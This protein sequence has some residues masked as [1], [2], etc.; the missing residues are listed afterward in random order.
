MAEFKTRYLNDDYEGQR[1]L[2]VRPG[3]SYFW[4]KDD[5]LFAGLFLQY[6]VELPQNYHDNAMDESWLYAGILFRL[7][8]NVDVGGYYARLWQEWS[9]SSQYLNKNGSPYR[10]SS[11]NNVF[12]ALL[13]FHL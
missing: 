8:A 5:R 6:E 13:I 4:L 7:G 9:S 11:L 1:T 3:L 10:V 2:M 12:N